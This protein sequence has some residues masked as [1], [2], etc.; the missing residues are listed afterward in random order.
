M[1]TSVHN[2]AIAEHAAPI[3]GWLTADSF[4]TLLMALAT[5][6]VAIATFFMYRVASISNERQDRERLDSIKRQRAEE[7]AKL[8]NFLLNKREIFRN[9]KYLLYDE[10]ERYEIVIAFDIGTNKES[11][12]AKISRHNFVMVK[13]KK[14]HDNILS[15]SYIGDYKVESTSIYI[16]KEP[17]FDSSSEKWETLFSAL[18]NSIDIALIGP[19]HG[20]LPLRQYYDMTSQ[21]LRSDIRSSGKRAGHV[22]MNSKMDRSLIDAILSIDVVSVR[23]LVAKVTHIDA[24]DTKGNTF[25]H[26]AVRNAHNRIMNRNYISAGRVG[27][28]GVKRVRWNYSLKLQNDLNRII[29]I[30]IKAGAD[31]NARD[32]RGVPVIYSAASTNNPRA[33]CI[34]EKS[35]ADVNSVSGHNQGTAI[36]IASYYGWDD[37]ID[38]LVGYGAVADCRDALDETPLHKASA[39]GWSSTIQKLIKQGL[40]IHDKNK[41]DETPLHSASF[42][43]RSRAIA[44]LMRHGASKEVNSIDKFGDTPLHKASML[45]SASAIRRLVGHGA[46]INA[47]D[48]NGETP[49]HKAST[50]KSRRAVKALIELGANVDEKDMLGE[51][52][53]HKASSSE[54]WRVIDFLI[55]CRSVVNERNIEGKTPLHIAI[56]RSPFGQHFSMIVSKLIEHRANV[57]L[58]DAQGNSP[59]DL[60]LKRVYHQ[61]KV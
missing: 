43:G 28:R 12:T 49:L 11:L 1:D 41:F 2:L 18:K 32:N 8:A 60:I 5:L 13:E 31:V 30:L 34:L 27:M 45:G 7:L 22:G 56:E 55:E 53:L 40:S 15:F 10:N 4:S 42:S 20:F 26:Y 39:S 47:R 23:E 33:I 46:T 35:G 58:K 14:N 61:R 38:R 44:E 48:E 54:S 6:G 29:L 21:K 16:D 36:H 51:T 19:Q 52:A 37:V 24:R 3:G 59:H 57:H 50:S 17:E 25:L 9:E